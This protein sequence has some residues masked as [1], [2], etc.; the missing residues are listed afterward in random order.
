MVSGS[1]RD[2]LKVSEVFGPT[3]QGEGFSAGQH[4]LFIRLSGCNLQCTWCDTAYTWAFTPEKASKTISGKLYNEDEETSLMSSGEAHRALL[5]LWDVDTKPTLIVVSGGEPMM[6]QSDGMFGLFERLY[7]SGN[8]IHIETAGTIAPT[9]PIGYYVSQYNVSPK[10]SHSGNLKAKRY[11]P[12]ALRALVLTGKARF[13]F[14]VQ[15]LEDLE[16]VKEIVEEVGI[17]DWHVQVMPEGTDPD[18]L[19]ET[20]QQIAEV[21]IAQGWGISPRLHVNIWADVRGK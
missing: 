10:L 3:I 1:L 21:A 8:R 20:T 6:Q 14:V 19:R 2:K 11:K 15:K 4:C 18:T 9:G 16:E 7:M 17:D 12:S 5:N 13:K